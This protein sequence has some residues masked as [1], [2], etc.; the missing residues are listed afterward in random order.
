[1]IYF[2]NVLSTFC[3]VHSVLCRKVYFCT[4]QS[5]FCTVHCV[6]CT[7][8]NCTY[9]GLMFIWYTKY[10]T[11]T[12]MH[13]VLCVMYFCT[14][15]FFKCTLYSLHKYC[16]LKKKYTLKRLKTTVQ[17]YSLYSIVQMYFVLYTASFIFK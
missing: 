6:S 1:M 4:V 12:T 11:F 2:D 7:N 15:F 17:K 13:Y 8:Y 10:S 16:S 14:V 9:Y 5:I 3:T